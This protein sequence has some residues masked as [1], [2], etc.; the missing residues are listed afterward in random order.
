MKEI[1][2]FCCGL[3]VVVGFAGTLLLTGINGAYMLISPRAWY[4]LPRWLRASGT[5]TEERYGS[6]WGA[7]QV[8]I[9]GAMCLAVS[10]FI[11]YAAFFRH[12]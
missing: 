2:H 3:A 10:A 8:R 5:L 6:G 1:V 11:L 7:I 4:R 12:R 9:A